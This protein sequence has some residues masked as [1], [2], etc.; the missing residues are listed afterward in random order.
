MEK[1]KVVSLFSG[2]GG[3][4]LGFIDA[5]FEVVLAIDIWQTALD[6]CKLNHPNLQTICKSVADFSNE[7]VLQLKLNL[8]KINVICG[9]P[10]CQGFSLAGK[11]NAFDPR[12][13]LWQDYFRFVELFNPDYFVMENVFGMTSMLD[14]NGNKIIDQVVV[15]IQELGYKFTLNKLFYGR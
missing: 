5:G 2:C 4:D 14:E 3:L 8:P 10:P 1:P 13:Q 12:N 7:E 9:G 15:K 11:R 6:T